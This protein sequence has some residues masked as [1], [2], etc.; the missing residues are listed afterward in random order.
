MFFKEIIEL[1]KSILTQPGFGNFVVTTIL[2][3]FLEI[4]MESFVVIFFC[5]LSKINSIRLQN[6]LFH[7]SRTRLIV[8]NIPKSMT[9]NRLKEIFI[10]AVIS[11]ASKQNPVILQVCFF[12]IAEFFFNFDSHCKF[13]I[14]AFLCI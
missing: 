3:F 2:L 12:K 7:V 8:Y 4:N 11:R 6:V 10:N 13:L 1:I 9:E 14:T 5:R